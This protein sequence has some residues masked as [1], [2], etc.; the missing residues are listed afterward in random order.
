MRLKAEAGKQTPEAVQET[1]RQFEAIFVQ[2]MLKAMRDASPGEGMFES[3]QTEFY[4]DMYDQQLALHMVKGRGLGIS[5]MLLSKIGGQPEADAAGTQQDLAMQ[6]QKA[7]SGVV[8]VNSQPLIQQAAI[9]PVVPINSVHP[10]QP[11]IR[12]TAPAPVENL[13]AI[14]GGQDWRPQSPEEFIRDLMPYAKEGAARLGVA[15]GVLIAQSALETGWGKKVIRHADGR[16]SFNLFGIKAD[17]AWAGD[18]VHVSTL[19]YQGGV[20]VETTRSIS[21]I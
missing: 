20:A 1:A 11:L 21:F 7:R 2:S 15:P 16:S 17:P 10:V 6:L 12:M 13:E 3:D 14:S 19:E 8:A 18:K 5:N 9:T 4:R